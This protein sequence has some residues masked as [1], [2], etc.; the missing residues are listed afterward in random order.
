[1]MFKSHL[2]GKSDSPFIVIETMN[3]QA[4]K[5]K[6]TYPVGSIAI[7]NN[8][9]VDD[10]MHSLPSISEAM[11]FYTEVTDML[12]KHCSM[13]MRRFQSNCKCTG[14]MCVFVLL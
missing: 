14:A 8:L 7:L 2:F 12:K 4:R 3:H 1:M 10:L 9:L 13:E 6:E 11:R 5:Y